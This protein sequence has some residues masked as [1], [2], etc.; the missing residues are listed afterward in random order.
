LAKAA[1]KR[2]RG[3]RYALRHSLLI[4]VQNAVQKGFGRMGSAIQRLKGLNPFNV[5]YVEAVDIASLSLT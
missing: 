2:G 1:L 3:L 4:A 5:G